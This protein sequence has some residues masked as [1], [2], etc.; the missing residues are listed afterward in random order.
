MEYPTAHTL[1]AGV[2]EQIR[3]GKMS[4]RGANLRGAYLPGA[5][6]R[7][8]DLSGVDLTEAVLDRAD[9]RGACLDEANLTRAT[10]RQVRATGASFV[11][12]TVVG[13]ILQEANLQQVTMNVG[14]ASD[15]R[16]AD[17]TGAV[18]SRSEG[19]DISF[20]RANLTDAQ[21]S[22]GGWFYTDFRNATLVRTDFD[23][24]NLQRAVFACWI[25]DSDG[26]RLHLGSASMHDLILDEES[27]TTLFRTLLREA[28]A[29]KKGCY[30]RKNKRHPDASVAI[31]EPVSDSVQTYLYRLASLLE[32][33]VLPV[34]EGHKNAVLIVRR[35]LIPEAIRP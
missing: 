22:H 5:D 12:A 25:G 6:L 8:A 2:I 29:M 33:E 28:V 27:R 3:T 21:L 32:A 16:R 9:L 31:K 1:P 26:E 11:G 4:I 30:L 17:L 14:Y 7:D 35:D 23:G 13:T 10:M 18:L 15:L 19:K 34:K 24:S 20:H